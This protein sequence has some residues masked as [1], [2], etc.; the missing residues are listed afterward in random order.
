ME[1]ELRKTG[2]DLIGDAP[3]GTHFCQF[4]QNKEDL[5]DILIPYFKS[6]LENN[7]FCMWITSDPLMVEEARANLRKAVKNLDDYVKKGQIEI[8]DYSQWYTKSGE[9][10]ADEVLDGWI[11]KE[12]QALER[13]FHG[14]RLTGN[15]FW[16]EE[17]DWRNFTE[18]EEEINNVIGDYKMIAVCTYALDKCGAS[19]I[20][21]VVA[22]HQFALVKRENK[23]EI[24]ESSERKKAEEARRE[25]ENRFKTLA[26]SAFEGILIHER[27]KVFDFNK[28]FKDMFGYERS[29]L[30]SMDAMKLIAPESRELVRSNIRS[31]TKQSYEAMGLR[32]DGSTF[33]MEINA[34]M[35]DYEGKRL[36]VAACRDITERKQAEE[37][38]RERIKELTCLY[39]VNRDLQKNLSTNDLCK[40]AIG[41]LSIAMQFPEITV[42]MIEVNDQRFTLE[43][44]PA[45]LSHGLHA[46]IRGEKE[47]FG[48]L[49]VYYS[50]EKPFLI[51][52]EQDLV[53]SI[54]EA[55]STW[56]ERKQAEEALL[57]SESKLRQSQKMEAV[58]TLAGGIAHE[59]NNI[60]GIIIG[61]TELAIDDVPEWNPAKE[62]LK[63]IRAASMRA[64]DV[65]RHI[66][67][68]AR[69]T[70]AQ[71]QPIQISTIIRDSLK[72]MRASIPTTIEIRQNLSCE[73]EMILADPTEI[74]QILMNFCTNSVHALSEETGVLE[75]SLESISLDKDSASQYEN[76][77]TG[78][79]VKLTVKDTG[80]GI[81][82]KIMDR[83][84]DPY[85]TT[86][87]IG[88]G[89][90]MGLAVAYGI[91]KKH[92]GAIK[93]SSELG[94]GTV[95]EVLFPL[96]DEGAEHEVEEE[97]QVLPTGTERI[98]IV[99]DEPSIARMVSQMLKRL[100]YDVVALLNP[101]EALKLF[102]AAPTRF[103]L[104]ITD[105]AM[106]HMAG[107]RLAQELMKIRQDIP[108][109]LC[110]GHSARIDEDRAKELGLA[111][112]VMKPLV[113]RDFANTV[114]RVL[115]TAKE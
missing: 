52:D 47:V 88:R 54:A 109:I 46:D 75:V 99:D 64:K 53:N 40:R 62:C 110:T 77:N 16:L 84:F 76:L 59:F 104:V 55:L 12:N 7:E 67:S 22:N 101:K 73:S 32:K 14:L 105:M 102:M 25:S 82:P 48:H 80:Q 9:F 17:K 44:P 49:W 100:G 26:E 50:E 78:N 70:P 28:N 15:T 31:E 66:L 4:Y 2:I 41:H 98:L 11:E 68:F 34:R 8:M 30:V 6:G 92:D 61:N 29:E 103:D 69:K 97:P 63:E 85:F 93:A 72:L 106:P 94:K 51:P 20:M 13:G 33:M 108:V 65:V 86:K 18:Y 90:G 3:W 10:N 19:E 91:V 107:D 89:T 42:P 114:R 56:F 71:R 21:D 39:G 57:K 115:D 87:D 60:L 43:N 95:F 58:G 1:N 79:F 38:L 37:A 24:V 111:A 36:R 23:W 5:L 45:G 83:I 27:A 74:N 81:D 112:Y 96:I 113:T 35:V